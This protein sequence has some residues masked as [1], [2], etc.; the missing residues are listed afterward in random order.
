MMKRWAIRAQWPNYG[1]VTFTVFDTGI[2]DE[3]DPP[4]S[5]LARE[6]SSIEGFDLANVMPAALGGGRAAV[7]IGEAVHGEVDVTGCS[8]VGYPVYGPGRYI[9]SAGTVISIERATDRL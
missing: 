1:I 2:I 5:P 4:N 6:F 9:H 7:A 3:I 8:V